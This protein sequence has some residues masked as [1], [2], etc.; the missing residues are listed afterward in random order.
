[1]RTLIFVLFIV[2]S[3][4]MAQ[5]GTTKEDTITTGNGN[6]YNPSF[7]RNLYGN[8]TEWLVFERLTN[9]SSFS[10]AKRFLHGAI[11]DSSETII[12]RT[13]ASE[14]QSRPDICLTYKS[15]L[16]AWQKR[17]GGRWNIYCSTLSPAA[18]TWSS[19][20]ALTADTLNSENVRIQ[21]TSVDTMF[22]LAWQ[23]KNVL[24]LQTYPIATIP[25][26][27]T[28]AFSND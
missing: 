11:W 3:P 20:I 5:V 2:A 14:L 13:A 18:P 16:I 9:D 24:R 8:G 27:D 12:S 4:L 22:M 10:V 7:T 21:Q 6:E 28:I 26:H 19:P 1:L 15:G 23:N 17:T 25:D